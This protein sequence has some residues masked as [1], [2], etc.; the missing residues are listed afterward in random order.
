MDLGH[1]SSWGMCCGSREHGPS[2]GE[3]SPRTTWHREKPY[4]DEALWPEDGLCE[5]DPL[6]EEDLT[7]LVRGSRQAAPSRA[8][9]QPLPMAADPLAVGGICTG[10]APAERSPLELFA[11]HM[12]E[13][14]VEVAMLTPLSMDTVVAPGVC[15]GA[16]RPHAAL[17]AGWFQ[18]TTPTPI[19]SGGGSSPSA[20]TPG[21]WGGSPGLARCAATPRSPPLEWAPS[22]GVSSFCKTACPSGA[23]SLASAGPIDVP[24]PVRGPGRRRFEVL[25]LTPDSMVG[26]CRMDLLDFDCSPGVAAPITARRQAASGVTRHLFL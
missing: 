3:A 19:A 10:D 17:P 16:S 8:A 6:L 24:T 2:G 7:M 1:L 21:G 4:V 25:L 15:R 18:L 26:A 12:E 9:L 22:P 11:A 23:G 13:G 14:D 5:L 20:V